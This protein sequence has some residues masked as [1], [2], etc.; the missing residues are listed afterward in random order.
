MEI[1]FNHFDHSK[2][3]IQ[4]RKLFHEC[5]P[6]TDGTPSGTVEH[7][8][9]KF[10]SKPGPLKSMEYSAYLGD[11]MVGYYAAIPYYYHFQNKPLNIGMVCD[12]MTGVKA[13]GKGVF[14]KLGTYSTSE[15]GKVGF[16]ITTG[17]PIRPE[18]LP[19]H[20]KAGWQI[21]LELPL[22]VSFVSF[23]SLLNQ[24][25]MGFITPLANILNRTITS[26][27][28]LIFVKSKSNIQVEIHSSSETMKLAELSTF[29]SEWLK[30]IP[31]GLIKDT[32]FLSWRLFAPGKKYEII[33]LKDEGKT[34][35]V[36]I[37]GMVEKE[38]IPCM[39]ILDISILRGYYKYSTLMLK[40]LKE[41]CNINKRE[42]ILIMI[43]KYWA[44]KY[45]LH[46][47][48]FIKSPFKFNLIVKNL[49]M[50]AFEQ[51]LSKPESWHVMWL[52]S[53]NL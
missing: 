30:E 35:G 22:Y 19:G 18:V 51:S 40:S 24:K 29:Y 43:S 28:N 53:D 42:M 44:K 14:T 8:Y 6:E 48:I 11:N 38:G 41:I 39:G 49:N 15:I 27:I 37:A 12:V 52:D 4:Q 20:L 13:R 16:G 21:K 32:N 5:F 23:K 3:L 10:H 31:I 46:K 17:Y 25:K 1:T 50:Q 2:E 26:L 34:V 33:R 9:W 7:Y 36:L 45:M 47:S